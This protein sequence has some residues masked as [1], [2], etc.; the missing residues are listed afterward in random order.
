MDFCSNSSN[1]HN[2]SLTRS[3]V[4]GETPEMDFWAWVDKKK[5]LFSHCESQYLLF[6]KKTKYTQNQTQSLLNSEE[7]SP[8]IPQIDRLS[9]SGC[10]THCLSIADLWRRPSSLLN[11]VDNRNGS[12][13]LN[14]SFHFSECLFAFRTN[15]HVFFLMFCIII[16]NNEKDGLW[17]RPLFFSSCGFFKWWQHSVLFSSGVNSRSESNADQCNVV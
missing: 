17:L 1:A 14:L 13:L 15:N 9:F 11:D 8:G 10:L 7:W 2:T 4:E 6:H 16:V 3:S 12:V 5:T